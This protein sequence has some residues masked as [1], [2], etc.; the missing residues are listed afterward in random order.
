MVDNKVNIVSERFTAKENK[1]SNGGVVIE[2]FALPFDKPSRNGFAYRK[3]SVI[4]T[5]ETLEGRPM[6]FNHNIEGLPIGKVTEVTVTE[7]G[8]NYRAEILPTTDEEK[9]IAE[10]ISNG[11]LEHVSIQCIYENA[12]VNKET[13][14]FHVDV[15]EF[16]ELSVVGVPGFADTTA[17]AVE[18]LQKEEK[19]K[20]QMKR[21][22]EELTEKPS[23]EEQDGDEM[24]TVLNEIRAQHEELMNRLGV[25]ESRLDAMDEES[26]EEED[27]E[28]K[29]EESEEETSEESED[30][31]SE[32]SEDEKS[33]ESEDDKSEEE[34]DEEEDKAVERKTMAPVSSKSSQ[35]LDAAALRARRLSSN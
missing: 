35:N 34:D 1:S 12:D 2:G 28:D 3:E 14:N 8:L 33:E 29:A 4:K 32:E 10:K 9:A 26:S 22:K 16:L 24:E 11:L 17:Q 18:S 5:A 31:K 15:R 7:K 19:V 25:V 13:G 21:V 20:L 27:S 23:A 30:E 6:F